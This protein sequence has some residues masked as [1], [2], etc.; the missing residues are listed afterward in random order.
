MQTQ[1]GHGINWK[2][3]CVLLYVNNYHQ[4]TFSEALC[5]N[6]KTN[7]IND[8]WAKRKLTWMGGRNIAK[9]TK[10]KYSLE[11][12][13]DMLPSATKNRSTKTVFFISTH[14]SHCY[15]KTF[16]FWEWEST[17]LNAVPVCH[18]NVPVHFVHIVLPPGL[19]SFLS[20]VLCG[21]RALLVWSISLPINS[22]EVNTLRD[23]TL[24][25][26][27][28]LPHSFQLLL[29]HYLLIQN[30]TLWVSTVAESEVKCPTPTFPEFPTPAF[31]KFLTPD[32]NSLAKHECN[33]AVNNFVATSS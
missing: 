26:W 9:E 6:V 19:E 13:L 31:P 32:S 8:N 29:P 11:E 1:N 16:D 10:Q 3:A 22:F 2:W 30:R 4:H 12:R 14:S 24:M 33:L 25:S 15:S 17:G 7:T 27:R 18:V 20:F 23:N 21:T 28:F 5:I